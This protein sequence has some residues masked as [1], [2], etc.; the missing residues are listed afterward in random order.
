MLSLSI[1]VVDRCGRSKRTQLVDVPLFTF[2][3]TKS[4]IFSFQHFDCTVSDVP[5]FTFRYTKRYVFHTVSNNNDD[6]KKDK[7]ITQ[8]LG[9]ACGKKYPVTMI[10]KPLFYRSFRAT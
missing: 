5:L 7:P 1:G 2:R 10:S 6:D 9:Y 3:G 4:H 8:P